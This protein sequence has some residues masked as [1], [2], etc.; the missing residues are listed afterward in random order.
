MS[1]ITIVLS[2]VILHEPLE[3]PTMVAC[4][5]AFA[6]FAAITLDKHTGTTGLES[7]K[8]V[9]GILVALAGA[10]CTSAA[11]IVTRWL[12][13]R[14]HSQWNVLSLGVFSTL[15]GS[16]LL[17][18]EKSPKEELFLAFA[19]WKHAGALFLVGFSSY[20]GASSINRALQL[21][22]AGTTG[23]LRSLDIP[24]SILLGCLFLGE[25]I[26]STQTLLGTLVILFA[27]VS[28]GYLRSGP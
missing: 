15:F 13:R 8:K 5:V 9:A 2:R 6:G 25:R 1:Q 24:L 27:S 17:L 4:L 3:F 11:H 23:V 18:A 20:V 26:V 14:V 12:G 28:L 16:L 22:P 7:G 19:S 21:I 10:V